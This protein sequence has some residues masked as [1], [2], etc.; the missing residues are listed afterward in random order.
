[1]EILELPDI[2]E[3]AAS[4]GGALARR[5]NRSACLDPFAKSIPSL[6]IFPL[7]PSG[8]SRLWLVASRAFQEGRIAIVTK[9]WRGM[10]WMRLASGANTFVP[11][12]TSTAYGEAVWS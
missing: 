10:R 6:E 1:M 9:R 8:K 7:S 3:I 4:A 5:A 11:D 2:E 12:E